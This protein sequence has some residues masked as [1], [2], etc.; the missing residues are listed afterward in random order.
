MF[1]NLNLVFLS[2][3]EEAERFMEP[4]AGSLR[5]SAS[6]FLMADLLIKEADVFN[7]LLLRSRADFRSIELWLS[8]A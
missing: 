6:G 1:C 4:R 5:K 8:C 2:V 3:K 7:C